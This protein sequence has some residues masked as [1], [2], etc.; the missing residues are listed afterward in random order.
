M[1]IDTGELLKDLYDKFPDKVPD[2]VADMRGLGMK[3]GNQQVMKFIEHIVERKEHE[4]KQK[5]KKS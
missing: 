1:V 3:V 2:K 4:A 5:A